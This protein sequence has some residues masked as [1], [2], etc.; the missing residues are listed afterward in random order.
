MTEAHTESGSEERAGDGPSLL[1]FAIAH[2]S[3]DR[4]ERTAMTEVAE[5]LGIGVEIGN[6]AVTGETP[7]P[8][9]DR[10]L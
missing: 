5:E 4:E 6:G 8:S 2:V 1:S 3:G 7:T 10:D 9:V